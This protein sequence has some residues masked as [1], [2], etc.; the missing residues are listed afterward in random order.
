MEVRPGDKVYIDGPCGS[1][2][3]AGVLPA[4]F[5]KVISQMFAEHDLALLGMLIYE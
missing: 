4:R 5:E 3:L 1:K 2:T